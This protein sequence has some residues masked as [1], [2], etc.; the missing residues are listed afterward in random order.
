MKL[1]SIQIVSQPIK[2]VVVSVVL[3]VVFV[4]IAVATDEMSHKLKDQAKIL[5]DMQIIIIIMY[6]HFTIKK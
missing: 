5:G 2:V 4:N 6:F 3:F 1:D